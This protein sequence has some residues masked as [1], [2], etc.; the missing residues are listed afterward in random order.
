MTAEQQFF[1]Q[2]LSD[3]IHGKETLFPDEPLDE[4]KLWNL[5]SGQNLIGIFFV[6]CRD[7]LNQEESLWN[8]LYQ[9]FCEEVF[10]SVNDTTDFTALSAA[11]DK[12]GISF[13]SM[14]GICIQKY[15][16]VPSL[17]TMGDIDLL[18][19]QEDREKTHS[20][21]SNLA[22]Q[23]VIHV[24]EVWTYLR[25]VVAYEIHDHMMYNPLA[26]DFDYCSYFDQV[27]E[28][29]VTEEGHSV[30]KPEFHFLFLITHAAKHIINKGYGIRGFLD[31]VFF[32]QG[33]PNM[34]WFWLE[35]QLRELRLLDFTKTCFAL[36]ERWFG[37]EMPLSSGQVN[38]EFFRDTTAKIFRDG[39]WGHDNQE[40]EFSSLAR[41]VHCAKEPYWFAVCRI[42]MRKLF[43]SYRN[44]Q[45]I[46]WYSFV[47]GRPWLLPAAW[48]YR[49]CYCL[50]YKCRHSSDLFMQPFIKTKEIHVREVMIDSW[51]L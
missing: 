15:Y 38:E 12:A 14:K 29:T 9:G 37:V 7:F 3:H 6:Q 45:Q 4:N 22:Y 1:F 26:N 2:V 49:F 48:I 28:Y 16:P 5:I 20:L 35:C 13:L 25:D 19:H 34:D 10:R 24:P 23:C 31:L 50:R 41:T 18:I 32:I 42:T 33:E 51:G 30:I 36:C 17:R 21:M 27:W 11:L 39:L 40:N 8:N 46:P 47:K 43:P 44:M